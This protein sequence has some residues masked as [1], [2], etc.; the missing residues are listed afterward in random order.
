MFYPPVPVHLKLN[1]SHPFPLG[2]RPGNHDF[3]NSTPPPPPPPPPRHQHHFYVCR[4]IKF[5]NQ[6]GGL[7]LAVVLIIRYLRPPPPA[8]A[9]QSPLQ[10]ASMLSN[11]RSMTLPTFIHVLHA[12]AFLATAVLVSGS[13][14]D[15]TLSNKYCVYLGHRKPSARA[16]LP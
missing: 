9:P 6:H 2:H 11:L 4:D 14:A 15:K 16:R 5:L 7:R 10:F 1:C 3:F 8:A 12:S 13:R